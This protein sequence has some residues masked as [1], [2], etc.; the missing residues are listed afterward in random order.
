MMLISHERK[1]QILTDCKNMWLDAMFYAIR[2]EDKS[3]TFEEQKQ[4]FFML[5]EE[6]LKAGIIKFD[7]PPLEEFIGVQGFWEESHD[8][9]I[10]YLRDNFPKD[11]D[12]ENDMEV[13]LYFYTVAPPVLYRQEDGSYCG[14]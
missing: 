4:I 1:Q 14:S 6:W 9:I 8:N 2:Y 3:I 10:K 11:A 12:S 7:T 13:N 5:V